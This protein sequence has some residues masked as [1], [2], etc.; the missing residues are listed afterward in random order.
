[1]DA[2]SKCSSDEQ[3]WSDRALEAKLATTESLDED[4]YMYEN[5]ARSMLA[6]MS[7]LPSTLESDYTC[8]NHTKS[9]ARA[10]LREQ[11]SAQ[12]EAR[13]TMGGE[14]FTEMLGESSGPASADMRYAQSVR[15]SA[16][17]ARRYMTPTNSASF[18]P[19]HA[20]EVEQVVGGPVVGG[21]E[22]KWRKRAIAHEKMLRH[23][24]GSL[25]NGAPTQ[26]LIAYLKQCTA[27]ART[28]PDAK[29]GAAPCSAARGVFHGA[30]RQVDAV[31]HTQ[32]ARERMRGATQCAERSSARSALRHAVMN[33]R[34]GAA[35]AETLLESNRNSDGAIV[36]ATAERD[37]SA[38]ARYAC[39]V[40]RASVRSVARNTS[41]KDQ[42]E[43]TYNGDM[44][45]LAERASAG[46]SAGAL[47]AALLLRAG[48]SVSERVGSRTDARVV[49]L[50][51]AD[52]CL[53]AACARNA[54]ASGTALALALRE[55]HTRMDE[56][57]N[58]SRGAPRADHAHVMRSTCAA[59]HQ[60]AGTQRIGSRSDAYESARQSDIARPKAAAQSA[61][62][63]AINPSSRYLASRAPVIHE[64]SLSA[65]TAMR[66]SVSHRNARASG[67]TNAR[68][69]TRASASD[70]DVDVDEGLHITRAARPSLCARSRDVMR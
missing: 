51:G 23:F 67:L 10:R 49:P 65:S 3:A 16:A 33:A 2:C 9:A 61:Q 12:D 59:H 46:A 39:D 6:D 8:G 28:L 57:V 26:G 47:Q 52:A 22:Y 14:H 35:R 11:Y 62:R 44:H 21:T 66:D 29:R 34:S 50:V 27:C 38:R 63:S 15:N 13:Q 32:A 30:Q 41:V 48:A 45:S 43:G 64:A 7:E 25:E 37:A 42:F 55:E 17:R 24:S 70:A 40:A 56:S 4:P 60:Y 54:S 36:M 5:H 69:C 58:Q 53:R 31:A 1:M 68:A 20:D 18:T 19:Q